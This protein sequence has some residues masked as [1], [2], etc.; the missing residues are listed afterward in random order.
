VGVNF[1]AW[2]LNVKPHLE[3]HP[4]E[5]LIDAD[6]KPNDGRLCTTLLLGDSWCAVEAKL[7]EK[8]ETTVAN[9]LDYDYEY[10][11]FSGPHSC[12]CPRCLADF[13]DYAKL[14]RGEELDSEIIRERYEERWV[15]FMARRAAHIFRKFRETIHQLSPGTK[16]SVYSGYQTPENPIRYGVNWDYV[17]ELQACDRVG[18]GYG[19]PMDAIP[20]TIGGLNGIPTVFGA[21]I[22]PYDT[23]EAVPLVPLTKA[24]LLR[25]ALDSTGGVLIYNRLPLD[26]RS[27]RAIAET[28]RLVATY[29]SL[30]L[31]GKRDCLPGYEDARVQVLSDG[32]RTL[33]CALNGGSSSLDL[34]LTLPAEAGSGREFY[35][36]RI[37][38]AGQTVSCPL[39]TGEAVVFVLS[40]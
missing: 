31:T 21:L 1:Q 39:T 8:I 33:V 20:R 35:S 28:T 5:R 26:G 9:T 22:R 4:N 19:R 14:D 15:D 27:W 10:S 37:V 13:R 34:R 30:F 3:K 11:P 23:K 38:D 40:R 2:S 12:Y 32:K 36:G 17:G 16:F 7:R 18:C 29:E 25:R 24:R 6:G